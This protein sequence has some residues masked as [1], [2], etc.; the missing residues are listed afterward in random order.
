[1]HTRIGLQ[2]IASPHHSLQHM[3]SPP[4]VTFST[5]LVHFPLAFNIKLVRPILLVFSTRLV[6]PQLHIYISTY[7][8]SP[9]DNQLTILV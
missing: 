3:A 9:H 5:W 2:L 4:Y 7:S 8:N 1:M 6:R